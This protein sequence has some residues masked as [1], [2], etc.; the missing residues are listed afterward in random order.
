VLNSVFLAGSTQPLAAASCR[1]IFAGT[2]EPP[3][4]QFQKIAE[5]IKATIQATNQTQTNSLTIHWAHLKQQQRPAFDMFFGTAELPDNRMLEIK[6]F[7]EIGDIELARSTFNR[8]VKD[9]NF[10]DNQLLKAG[11]KIIKEIKNTGVDYSLDNRSRQDFFI[12][13]SNADRP[14]GFTIDIIVD[15]ETDDR[16]N[17]K[18]QSF[19]YV[20]LNGRRISEDVSIFES[21]NTFSEFVWS[22]KTADRKA[23][24]LALDDTGT[25]TI[26]EIGRKVKERKYSLNPAAVPNILS[27]LALRRMIDSDAEKMVIDIINAGGDITP[28]FVAK[29]KTEDI[30]EQKT[31]EYVLLVESLAQKNTSQKIYL[32]SQGEIIK[33][34]LDYEGISTFQ[35]LTLKEI[36]K[37]FP[38]K[39]DMILQ[40]SKIFIDQTE[41]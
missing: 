40:K 16:F 39:A 13:K 20:R 1:Y 19:T 30:T 2:K 9:I 33:K 38:E 3:D 31:A 17:I 26:Q 27:D 7:Q 5:Q 4:A 28:T 10:Q 18:A 34:V 23:I 22:S 41:H 15:A 32:N 11:S 12:I 37:Y 35:R 24:R 21:D 14:I 25:V 6:V 29:S 36:A 8:I